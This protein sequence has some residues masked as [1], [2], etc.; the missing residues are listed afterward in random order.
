M[1]HGP[2]LT[3]LHKDIIYK[4]ATRSPARERKDVVKDINADL[5]KKRLRELPLSTLLRE[6]SSARKEEAGYLDQP[7]SIACQHD[8]QTAVP[9]EVLPLIVRLSLRSAIYWKVKLSIRQA[10]WCARLHSLLTHLSQ[11]NDEETESAFTERSE[12]NLLWAS[13]DYAIR[14][15]VC[16]AEQRPLHTADLDTQLLYAHHA[17]IA[18]DLEM[19]PEAL[20]KAMQEAGIPRPDYMMETERGAQE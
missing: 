15:R 18:H 5:K 9:A 14:D 11:S 8:P 13:E 16:Q 2:K 19:K 12:T 7:W 17:K 1:G 4:H 3:A 10:V 6:V 20:L